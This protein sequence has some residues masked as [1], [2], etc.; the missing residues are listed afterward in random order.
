MVSIIIPVYNVEEYIEE[1]LESILAQTYKDIELLVV[2]D[3]S[4]DNSLGL[5]RGYE[6]KFKKIRIFTQQNKGVSEAR[7]LAL[8]YASGEFVLYIDPDDFLEPIMIEKMVNKAEKYNSDITICGYYLYY[9]KDNANNK[10]FTYG[11]NENKTLSSLEVIDMMLNYKLQGQLWN[12]LF[13]KDLL[14]NNNFKFEPGRYIQDI[15]P[16]FKAVLKS[17]NIIFVDEPLYYYRQRM[18]STVNKKSKKL[19][20]DYFHAMYSIMNYIKEENVKVNKDSYVA[21]R[22]I[23]LSNFIA[24]YTNYKKDNV[25]K[26]FY[27][28]EFKKLDIKINEFISINNIPLKDKLRVVLWKIRIFNFIK[29]LKNK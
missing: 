13:K 21:F 29:N 15:F 10:I 8:N 4:T 25:Y 28:S 26:D 16:V 22:T 20:E 24:M 5:I 19:A 11:I 17:N 2:D 6:N 7:N 23:V 12:K 3:G 18:S 1:C 9:S 14:I 27:N